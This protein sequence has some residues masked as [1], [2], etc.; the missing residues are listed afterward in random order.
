MPT[1][2]PKSPDGCAPCFC[3]TTIWLHAPPSR[4]ASC[5]VAQRAAHR[6]A[7]PLCAEQ[8]GAAVTL[9]VSVACE[10]WPKSFSLAATRTLS[11]HAHTC[12]TQRTPK[13][14]QVRQTT[15]AHL[16]CFF[17]LFFAALLTVV[18]IA[19]CSAAQRPA[20]DLLLQ[21]SNNSNSQPADKH[22]QCTTHMR[23]CL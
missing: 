7:S 18:G 4:D 3:S 2:C 22:T 21:Q 9:H 11:L 12:A 10:L 8:G 1:C 20:S 15:V 5:V 6:R 23:I 16:P 19:L 13:H 14:T 17:D